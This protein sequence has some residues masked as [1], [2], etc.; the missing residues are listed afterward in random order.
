MK[1]KHLLF[2]LLFFLP[3]VAM[4][5]NSRLGQHDAVRTWTVP[6]NSFASLAEGKDIAQQIIDV[7]GLKPNFEVQAA[8]VPNAAAVVSRGKRYVLYNPNF[9]NQLTRTTGTRWAAISVLAHEIGH[10]LNGHTVTSSGSQPAIE[11]EA[12]EFSGFV[13]RKMG[14]SLA[15]AQAAMK[16]IAGQQA[17]KTHPGRYDRLASIQKGWEHADDQVNGRNTAKVSTQPQPSQPAPRQQQQT[18]SRQ[19]TRRTTSPIDD[20]YIVADVSFNSDP[21]SRYYITSR[22]NVVKVANNNLLVVGK[23][24][25]MKNTQYPYLMYDEQNT[26][27][28]VDRRGN[29]VTRR[30]QRVGQL[31]AR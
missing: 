7:V 16:A 31:S 6:V 17:T 14:A 15:E 27:Y 21:N 4:A 12:D 30:G 5:Q 25:S 18:A 19:A 1:N 20:R 10:H 26:Q 11:L 3:V 24:A 28:L 29:I 2:F 9:I 22:Y 13:L 8:N 23:L